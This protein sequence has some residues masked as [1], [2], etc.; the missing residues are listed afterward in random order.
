MSHELLQWIWLGGWLIY[1]FGIYGQSGRRYR[2]NQKNA[3]RTRLGDA[4]LDFTMF[5]CWQ[6]LPLVHIFGSALDFANYELPLWAGWMGVG[7]F[8]AAILI[9]YKAYSD[10]GANWSPK[11]DIM[12]DH[13]LITEG[14]YHYIRHPIYAGIWLWAL[15]QP[16]LIPNW[17]A[18]FAMMIAFLPL[19]LIRMPREEQMMLDHFGDAYCRYIQQTG[20][21]IPKRR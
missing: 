10:L 5:G 13:K 1:L 20:R 2:R 12:A 17:I 19:Y 4:L 6:I 7:V 3:E 9:L 15:A 14:I 11:L 21:L 18:G 8:A 16:L